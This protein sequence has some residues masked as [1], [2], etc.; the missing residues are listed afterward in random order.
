MKRLIFKLGGV[1]LAIL[2]ALPAVAQSKLRFSVVGF[3]LDVTDFSAQSPEYKKEQIQ[4]TGLYEC[5]D[6]YFIAYKGV[7]SN[8]YAK[9]NFQYKYEVGKVYEDY[10]DY[11]MNE[12]GFGLSVWTK[13]QAIEYGNPTCMK[14]KVYY[15]DVGRLVRSGVKIRCTKIEI[16]EVLN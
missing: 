8:G 5:H 16:L 1:I 10:C 13:A 7:R 4:K 12:N 3:E 6:D 2:L 14:V 11:S 9:F 15:K